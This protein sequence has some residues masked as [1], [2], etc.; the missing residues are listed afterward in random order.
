MVARFPYGQIIPNLLLGEHCQKKLL[1]P[2]GEG[3]GEGA[4]HILPPKCALFCQGALRA[5]RALC[6]AGFT[7]MPNQVDVHG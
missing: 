2:F 3:W 1:L 5:E 6:F 7:P 4:S